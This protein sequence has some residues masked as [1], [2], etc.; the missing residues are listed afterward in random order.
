MDGSN[1][2]FQIGAILIAIW[3]FIV[4]LG[5]IFA[6]WFLAGIKIVLEYERLVVFRLGKYRRTVG[7][8]VVYILPWLEKSRKLDIRIITA[9]IPR[10]EVMTKDNIPVLVNAVVYFNVEQPDIAIIKLSNYNFAV[11]QYAQATL[12]DVIGR[13]ELDSVLTEREKIATEIK[14]NVDRET[15]NWGIDVKSIKIQEI[16]LPKE[17]KRAMAAQAEAEREK[18]AAIIGAEGE[19]EAAKNLQKAANLMSTEPGA[20]HL[21][22]LQTIRDIS[23]DPSQKIVIFMP[24]VIEGLL[25]KL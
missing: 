4:I 20:L 21:R 14:E 22:T 7:P 19:L 13:L 2:I 15:S 12:R 18:R 17:M 24:S 11:Q 5:I 25:K 8:G 10:Q 9:E 1:M 23:Q 16:E 3:V 6:L